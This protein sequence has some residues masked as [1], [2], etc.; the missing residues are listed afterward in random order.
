MEV[1]NGEQVHACNVCNKRCDLDDEVKK[2]IKIDHKDILI[3]IKKN[4]EED[5]DDEAFLA[6]FDDDGNMINRPGVAGA[7]L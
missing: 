5:K 2:H 3:E 1:L 4:I 7:V 6:R